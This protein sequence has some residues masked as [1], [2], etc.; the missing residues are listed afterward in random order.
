[1]VFLPFKNVPYLRFNAIIDSNITWPRTTI[2]FKMKRKVAKQWEPPSLFPL[3][4]SVS[5]KR[6]KT[7]DAEYKLRQLTLFRPKSVTAASPSHC[8]RWPRCTPS[9]LSCSFASGLNWERSS[10]SHSPGGYS[11]SYPRAHHGTL[12]FPPRGSSV[13]FFFIYYYPPSRL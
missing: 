7:R 13:D 8:R 6:E 1:M 11:M 10:S 5:K 12:L 3:P 4:L 9:R 2:M